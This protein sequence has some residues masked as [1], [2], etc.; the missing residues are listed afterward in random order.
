MVITVTPYDLALI[1]FVVMAMVAFSL[2]R[3]V[4]KISKIQSTPKHVFSFY[5]E[6]CAKDN[7]L[8]EVMA[9]TVLEAARKMD[10][11][12]LENHKGHK[13]RLFDETGTFD[14]DAFEAKEN[15]RNIQ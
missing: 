11:T 14:E 4:Q 15:V 1:G 3:L 6:S 7:H 2:A 13:V 12:K 9:D 8:G 5:C 10:W